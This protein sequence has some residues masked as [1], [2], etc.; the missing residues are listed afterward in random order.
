MR[1][2]CARAMTP[3]MTDTVIASVVSAFYYLRIVKIMYFDEATEPLDSAVPTD[4]RLVIYVSTAVTLL[5]FLVPS[6]IVE[7]AAA[8]AAALMGG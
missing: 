7:A 6:P 8:A 2:A 1:G 5:F 4:L 3:A